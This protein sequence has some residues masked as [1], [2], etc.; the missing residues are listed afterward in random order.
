MDLR[1]T[2]KTACHPRAWVDFTENIEFLFV[3]QSNEYLSNCI[4]EDP[5]LFP[6]EKLLF[7]CFNFESFSHWRCNHQHRTSTNWLPFAFVWRSTTCLSLNSIGRL[8]ASSSSPIRDLKSPT[9]MQGS[10]VDE[11]I[12]VFILWRAA[13]GW[14]NSSKKDFKSRDFVWISKDRR[15]IYARLDPV[16]ILINGH[17]YTQK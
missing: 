9:A 16:N 14:I 15:K 4:T 10:S 6:V 8:L 5:P 12:W 17:V 1:N 7:I 3:R 13:R 2:R 11:L